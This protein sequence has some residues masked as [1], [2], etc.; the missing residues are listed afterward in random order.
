MR[1][2]HRQG[3]KQSGSQKNKPQLHL[4]IIT[5]HNEKKHNMKCRS[6]YIFKDEAD[7][8]NVEMYKKLAALVLK[9]SDEIYPDNLAVSKRTD[10]FYH[11]YEKANCIQKERKELHRLECQEIHEKLQWLEEH[12]VDISIYEALRES[13][14]TEQEREEYW[15]HLFVALVAVVH[16]DFG[17]YEYLEE[18]FWSYCSTYHDCYFKT[19]KGDTFM[20]VSGKAQL[21]NIATLMDVAETPEELEIV[22]KTM[23]GYT[24]HFSKGYWF[25][26]LKGLDLPRRRNLHKCDKAV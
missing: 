14:I 8:K 18:A 2:I 11:S 7:R 15:M 9:V 17:D 23:I 24:R 3:I 6:V 12:G 25:D 4:L 13:D 20:W 10:R 19:K 16:V 21:M 5:N 22:S 1:F 26:D